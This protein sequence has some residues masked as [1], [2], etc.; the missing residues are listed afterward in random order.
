MIQ[1][2]RLVQLPETIAHKGGTVLASLPD[3]SLTT[4]QLLIVAGTAAL[5]TAAGIWIAG[6]VKKN[7]NTPKWPNRRPRR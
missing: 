6:E 2:E 3:L 5:F 4:Q 1:T 7:R